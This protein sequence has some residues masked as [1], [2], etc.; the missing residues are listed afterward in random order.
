MKPL[1]INI[2]DETA[3]DD[4]ELALDIQIDGSDPPAADDYDFLAQSLENPNRKITVQCTV[5]GSLISWTIPKGEAIA[6]RYSWRIR[7]TVNGTGNE[8]TP[9]KGMLRLN[10]VPQAGAVS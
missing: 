8:Q 5:N 4:I 9:V 3:G 10:K 6:G 1:I 7:Q 2:P